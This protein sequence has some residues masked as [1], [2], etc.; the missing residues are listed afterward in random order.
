MRRF[1]CVWGIGFFV[2]SLFV[3]GCGNDPPMAASSS[4]E[5]EW[6]GRLV[7]S[8]EYPDSV[9]FNLEQV[10]KQVSGEVLFFSPNGST[11]VTGTISGTSDKTGN[12]DFKIFIPPPTA[13]IIFTTFSGVARV[14]GNV[15]TGTYEV[16]I[17]IRDR[18]GMPLIAYGGSG[19][20]ELRP[21]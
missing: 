18:F 3:L 13:L 14:S 11:I 5:G 15:M 2:L 10:G 21:L 6:L 19:H 7:G 17:R 16:W 20:F 8:G 4:F 12:L 9:V 1:V